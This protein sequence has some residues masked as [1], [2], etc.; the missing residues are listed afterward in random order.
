M[1]FEKPVAEVTKFTLKDILTASDETTDPN[2]D[3]ANR[4][5]ADAAMFDPT[6]VC[7][8]TVRDMLGDPEDCGG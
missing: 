1:K 2:D 4:V 7:N 6:Y 8:G 5:G 3:L